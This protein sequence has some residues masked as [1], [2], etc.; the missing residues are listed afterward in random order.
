MARRS[1]R[2]RSRRSKP[3]VEEEVLEDEELEELS[4]SLRTLR[5]ILLKLQ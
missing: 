3:V 5:D 4:H 2:T 1:S